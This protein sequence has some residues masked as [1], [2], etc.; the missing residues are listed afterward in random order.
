LVLLASRRY[1]GLRLS[2]KL[3]KQHP[4]ETAEQEAAGLVFRPLDEAGARAIMAWRYPPPY[5]F[6]DVI[7]P[8]GDEEVLVRF[9]VDPRNGYYRVEEEGR[10]AAFCCFGH[11]AQVPGGDYTLPALDVGLGLRPGLCGRGQ[12]QRFV[13]GVLDFARR[14]FSPPALRS[15]VATFNARALRVWERAGFVRVQAFPSAA[16][17]TPF[18]VL[19]HRPANEST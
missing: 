11:D 3:R 13:E 5:D 7:A 8:P 9:F 6:Y 10:L 17:G 19:L 4:V 18:V 2:L 12:G 14:Q 15:T 16:D 1:D